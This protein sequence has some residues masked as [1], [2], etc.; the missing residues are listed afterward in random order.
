MILQSFMLLHGY[1][2]KDLKSFIIVV[3]QVLLILSPSRTTK[4]TC[5]MLR[6]IEV[7]HTHTLTLE[8]SCKK[9]W[10]CSTSSLILQHV[11]SALESIRIK[12]G[13]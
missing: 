2:M 8:Q 1:G 11:S 3:V 9:K 5:L 13:M 12:Y 10:G 4:F 7:L 6:H